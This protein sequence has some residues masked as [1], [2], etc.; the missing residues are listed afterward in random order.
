MYEIRKKNP[1]LAELSLIWRCMLSLSGP[2]NACT[3]RR[4]G[5]LHWN[6]ICVDAFLCSANEYINSFQCLSPSRLYF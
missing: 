2:V 5:I 6:C 3:R 4:V 1:L